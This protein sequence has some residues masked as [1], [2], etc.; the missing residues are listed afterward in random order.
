MLAKIS[1]IGSD[2]S[3]KVI[4]KIAPSKTGLV[5]ITLHN[6][7]DV[8]IDW[9]LKA[10]HH[11]KN[12]YGFI[13]PLEYEYGIDCASR[14]RVLLTFDDGFASNKRMAETI[15]K[16]LN[17]KAVF[18][19]TY[20]FIGLSPSDAHEF[21]QKNFYPN[22]PIRKIDGEMQAMDWNDVRWLKDQG[23]V[24][25]A[26]THQHPK[27]AHLSKVEK[28]HEIINTADQLE[29]KL[30][31]TVKLFAYPFGSVDSIDEDAFQMASKRFACAFSNV[32]G[33]IHE[34]PNRHFLY[35]QNVT[36]GIPMWRLDAIIQ[37]KLDWRYR[38][39]R[40]EACAKFSDK[41]LKG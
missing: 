24:I 2:F 25:G 26:H 8:Y 34:S 17:I 4:S 33:M 6:I 3:M 13:N 22:R 30:G 29:A 23:H 12:Q 39:A 38:G 16:D 35:R 36:P 37:G 20:G 41:Y 15:L 9:A 11:I 32:R 19:V 10:L 40:D 21:A 31:H 14:S 5:A 28:Q 27:L 18:F 7:T 1:A